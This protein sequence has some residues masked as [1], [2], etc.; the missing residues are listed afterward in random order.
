[1]RR[2]GRRGGVAGCGLE[3][4]HAIAA[5]GDVQAVTFQ[6][7]GSCGVIFAV[8]LVAAEVSALG[9]APTGLVVGGFGDALAGGIVA[10]VGGFRCLVGHDLLGG[11]LELVFPV[12]LHDR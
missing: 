3:Q 5:V 12:P 8:D 2:R 4:A 9:G 6:G 10:V 11:C 7:D 1:V